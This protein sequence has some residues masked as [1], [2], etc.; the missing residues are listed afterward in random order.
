[1]QDIIRILLLS[2]GSIVIMFLLTKLMGHRQISELS[3]FDYITSITIGS[4]AAEMAVSL[5]DSA[6]PAITAMIT[7]GIVATFLSW[8]ATKSIWARRHFTGK[9][10]I[11]L[12]NGTIYEDNLRKCKIDINK[13]LTQCRNSG[14]FD[15][16]KLQTALLEENGKISFLPIVTERPVT[17]GDLSLT[18]EQE[19][20]VAN[21]IIDGHIMEHNLTATGR[22]EIWLTRQ[23]SALGKGP[24]SNVLLAT[25]DVNGKLSVFTK[26]DGRDHK[27]NDCLS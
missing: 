17:P 8:I 4:I 11:L 21:V 16:S 3:M 9:P 23:L 24:L 15:V 5:E 12:N 18:P 14:Y 6:L 20:L 26:S 2:L 27:D 25:C 22:D 1:M 13:F 7:Y 19:Q 10:I